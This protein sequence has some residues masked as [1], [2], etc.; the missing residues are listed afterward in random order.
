MC[1]RSVRLIIE[2]V[3]KFKLARKEFAKDYRDSLLKVGY[4]IIQEG[5]EIKNGDIRIY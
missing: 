3:Y 2:D 5:C 1:A 4:D